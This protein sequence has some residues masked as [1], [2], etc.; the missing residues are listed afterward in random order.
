MKIR[1]V[2]IIKLSKFRYTIILLFLLFLPNISF[3]QNNYLRTRYFTLDDGLSQVS[4]NNLLLDNSGFIWI[5]TENGLNR[6]DGKEFKHFKYSESDSLTISGNYINKL[7]IDK[8]GRIW[9]GTVG[10][11]LNYYNQEQEVFHRFNLKFSHDKN[12]TISALTCDGDGNIC[13]GLCLFAAFALSLEQIAPLFQSLTGIKSFGSAESLLMAGERVNNLVRLFNLREGLTPEQDS[14]P[15]RFKTEPL[16]DGPCKGETVDVSSMVSVY[17]K[18]RGWTEEG[19]PTSGLLE[20]LGITVN[21]E[22]L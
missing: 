14:L 2:N 19:E 17:Y 20:K 16:P 12:E 4:C 11:G 22:T 21:P 6:F 10:N 13:S 7:I 18:V 1:N 15:E 9:I 8:S 5:A 3:P